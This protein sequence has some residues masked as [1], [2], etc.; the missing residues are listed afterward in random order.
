M[1]SVLPDVYLHAF[2]R[3]GGITWCIQ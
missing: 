2:R 3:V 1:H